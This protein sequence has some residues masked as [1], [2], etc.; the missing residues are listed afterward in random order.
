MT[1]RDRTDAGRRLARALDSL[2]GRNDVI[3]LGIP[4]GGVI[5]ACEVAQALGAPLDLWFAHKIGAPGNPEFA[6]G[7]VAATGEIDVDPYAAGTLHVPREYIEAEAEK[8]RARI[9]RRME[10]YRGGLPP[11]NVTGRTVV[12]VDDGLAT[13][14]TAR[15]AL[16]SLRQAAPA[17]LILAVPVAPPETRARLA[18][19]ADKV[20]VLSLPVSFSA[21][22][23][24][25]EEFGQTSDE[26]VIELLGKSR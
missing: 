13:G 10:Q 11:L 12:L 8:E 9:A 26:E 5:V 24:F 23:Q 25:Y 3:V 18:S 6:I 7:S 2:R 4:R 22:G 17:E 21:V 19:L 16:R 20:V 14:S 15:A 1:F